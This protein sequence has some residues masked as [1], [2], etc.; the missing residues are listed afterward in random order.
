MTTVTTKGGAVLNMLGFST[1]AGIMAPLIAL[2][3]GMMLCFPSSIPDALQMVRVFNISALVL[4]VVQLR[5]LI[6][7]LT[8]LPPPSSLQLV[9]VSGARL[10]LPLLREARQRLC[11][12][13]HLGYGSTE[14]GSMT[15]GN[16]ATLERHEGSAGYVRPWVEMEAVDADGR[17]VPPGSGGILRARSHEIAFYADDAGDPIETM[18]DG[19]FYPGDVGRIFRTAWSSSQAVPTK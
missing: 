16:G 12:N 18:R 1:I 17:T 4:A 3:M 11:N 9:A 14:M 7:A 10:P 13:I 19:W 15:A 8:G 2:P 6:D 5:G